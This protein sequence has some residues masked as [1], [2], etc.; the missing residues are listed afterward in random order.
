MICR[1]YCRQELYEGKNY[2]VEHLLICSYI[3]GQIGD[4]IP[5]ANLYLFFEKVGITLSLKAIREMIDDELFIE[6]D[7]E[8]RLNGM[9]D[10]GQFV[11][12]DSDVVKTFLNSGCS[13]LEIRLFIYLKGLYVIAAY[14]EHDC[15]FCKTT[16]VKNLGLRTTKDV[17]IAFDET[18]DKFERSGLLKYRVGENKE[19]KSRN[20]FVEWIA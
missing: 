2:N 11:Q 4:F 17:M 18:L 20:Y 16:V 9:F 10:K 7:K 1:V 13:A 15:A 14:N 5:K 6:K 8:V 19:Y 3:F 12:V